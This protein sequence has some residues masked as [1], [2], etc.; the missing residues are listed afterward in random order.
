MQG[1]DAAEMESRID[2]SGRTCV[3]F[4]GNETCDPVQNW[5]AMHLVPQG[6]PYWSNLDALF[7]LQESAQT[8]RSQAKSED[9]NRVQFQAAGL[10]AMV[11]CDRVKLDTFM[12]ET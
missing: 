5:R 6:Q 8:K 7:L 9:R 1:A 10:A 3:T 12:R 2:E 4:S 11:L